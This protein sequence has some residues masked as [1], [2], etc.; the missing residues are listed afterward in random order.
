[1]L[2]DSDADNSRIYKQS[3]NSVDRSHQSDSDEDEE[4]EINPQVSKSK[5]NNTMQ[6]HDSIRDTAL[7]ASCDE[8][9]Q[10]K[11]KSS[12]PSANQT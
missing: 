4:S 3:V 5:R 9:E 12:R 7:F 2:I 11:R 10:G 1:M 6:G 8:D